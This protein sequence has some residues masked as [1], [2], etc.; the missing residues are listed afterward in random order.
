MG[1]EVELKLGIKPEDAPLVALH[2]AVVN[3]SVNK[4]IARK[5]NTIYYDTTDLRLLD[6]GISLRIRRVSG[7]WIQSIKAVGGSKAGLHQRM[8]WEC[9][10]ANCQPDFTVILEPTLT[11]LFADQELCKALK[12]IFQTKVQRNEWQLDFGSGDRIELA[13]DRGQLVVGKNHEPISEIELELKGGK[14]GRLF[15]LALALQQV[16]PLRLKNDSK[17][18]NGYA[19]YRSSPLKTF[20]SSPVKLKRNAN[21]SSAFKEIIWECIN[22]LQKNQD[23]VLFGSDVEGVHQMRVALRRLRSTFSLYRKIIGGENTD[24]LKSELNWLNTILGEAR[25][26]DVFITQT[27]PAIIAQFESHMGLLKL[28]QKA[29]LAKDEAY[30]EVREALLSQRYQVFLLTLAAWLENDGHGSALGS[31]EAK[32]FDIANTMLNKRY[33]QLRQ[34]GKAIIVMNTEERHA[35][36]ISAKKLR[37]VAEFF[38][39]LYSS[40]KSSAFVRKL[41]QL[42]DCLGVLNDITVTEKLVQK[43]KGTRPDRK[44]DEA[45]YIIAGWNAC[46]VANSLNY[47][48]ELW[49]GFTCQEKFWC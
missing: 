24:L 39:T 34:K 10:V 26:L 47:L 11:K 22:H 16:M 13:L 49:D 14:K 40:K 1:S 35:T 38:A 23:M 17:A 36:R 44:T 18:Q 42:Q 20:K 48:E 12:P 6:A 28:D 27:I 41:S 33:K 46:K 9:V 45:M 32:V 25:D 43:L 3:A 4:P 30:K 15:D 5:I 37:Y 8:E 19:Y 2:P 29:R 7:R 21:A 31:K